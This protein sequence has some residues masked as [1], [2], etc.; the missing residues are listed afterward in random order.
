MRFDLRIHICRYFI[1]ALYCQ[2][3][4]AVVAAQDKYAFDI[5]GIEPV[6]LNA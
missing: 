2:C 5:V 4:C 3:L 6:L 1:G